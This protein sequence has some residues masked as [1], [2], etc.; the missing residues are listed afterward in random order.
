MRPPRLLDDCFVTDKARMRHDEAL[1]LLK[2][3]LAPV[4]GVEPVSLSAAAGRILDETVTAPHPVPLSDN[5]AVDGYAFAH[6]DYTASGGR[7]RIAARIAAGHPSDTALAPGT[8]ARIFTG[9]VMPGRADTVAMQEDTRV[10][11]EDGAA[12]A[13][14]PEGLKRG[15]NRRKAGEDLA[16]G[17]VLLAPGQRLRPQDVAALASVGRADA[18]CRE[19]LK[20][21]LV[22]TGDELVRPGRPLAPGQ[23]YDANHFLLASLLASVGAE[24]TDL[25]IAPD[26]EEAVAGLLTEA[27]GSHHA[28]V[29]SGG[30]SRGEE[31]HIVRMLDLIGRRHLWQLAVKP[32]RP[33]S[34]GQIGDCAVLG[35]PGNPVAAMVCFVLYARPALLALGGAV[36]RDPPRFQVPAAFEMRKKADRRE[37]LRGILDRNAEGGLVVSKYP[38]DGSGL[39]TSLREA[40]GLIEIPEEITAVAPG[41]PVAFVP[42]SELGVG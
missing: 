8:A 15:A 25:G 9:A 11:E 42:F 24:V 14:V 7:L 6:E 37:F 34:F 5:A 17:T 31:D 36:W 3:R 12:W 40:D 27:A 16:E 38:R 18:L 21:A 28:I 23:V 2:A 32:G 29:S 22:S 20:V 35:L 13:L 19:R 30:A 39:I 41:D 4:V 33:M 26:R 10:L 1:A